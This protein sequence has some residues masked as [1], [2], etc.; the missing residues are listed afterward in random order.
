LFTNTG[1]AQTLARIQSAGA[2]NIAFVP[3]QPP[4]SVSGADGTPSG[5]AIDLCQHVVSVLKMRLGLTTLAT[6]WVPTS[7][8][9]ALLTIESG[10]ADLVCGPISETLAARAHVSFSIPIYVSG[11]GAMVRKDAAPTLL[12][13]LNGQ[14]A[15]TGPTWRATINQGLANQTFAVHRGTTSEAWVRDR[16]AT[17]G[18][19]AKV[20]T[21][22]SYE[23][24]VDLVEKG[25]AG[26][27]FGDRVVLT[28]YAARDSETAE[29]RVVD[30]RFTLEPV[31]LAM[32]R[33]DEDFR[34]AVD[35]ALSELYRSG[36]YART[37]ST[38]FGAPTETAKLLLQAYSLP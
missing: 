2:I 8:E 38:H 36:G 31:A 17:L 6:K 29:L 19:I 20:V 23:D 11:I 18:V 15:H 34:L 4:F 5:Y 14:V 21:V 12:R 10:Q 22:S 37:Y 25:K 16:I 3:E 7:I 30:R 28:T 35:T 24:G 32:Q 33:G 27:F 1:A 26:A 13:V 9:D